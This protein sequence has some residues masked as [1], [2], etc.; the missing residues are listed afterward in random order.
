M[1]LFTPDE[2][3]KRI[4]RQLEKITDAEMVITS[5][6]ETAIPSYHFLNHKVSTFWDCEKS[7]VG[8]CVWDISEKG[9]HND[10]HC[11]YCGQPVERK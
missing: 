8:K 5:I 1:S 4:D 2:Y 10:C 7:P 11:Y 6:A 3:R 9:F